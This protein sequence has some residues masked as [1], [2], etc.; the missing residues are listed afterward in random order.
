MNSYRTQRNELVN[1]ELERNAMR[2]GLDRA[3]EAVATWRGR[4]EWLLSQMRGG[5]S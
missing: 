1:I 5:D 3:N 2:D 4:A